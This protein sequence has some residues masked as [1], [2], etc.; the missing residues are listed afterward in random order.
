M[1]PKGKLEANVEIKSP[2]SKF[3]EMFH[4]R[5]HHISNASGDK[6]QGCEL[7]EGNWG[8]VGSVV[9][10]K[11]FHGLFS[12]FFFLYFFT[13]FNVGSLLLLELVENLNE[14]DCCGMDK[15]LPRKQFEY[16]HGAK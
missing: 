16:D 12:S 5:P 7:H 9:C 13:L 2:P 10:A 15:P 11:Y 14:I 4:K 3:H 8:E 1:A 6:V